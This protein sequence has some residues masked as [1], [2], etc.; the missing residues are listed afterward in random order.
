MDPGAQGSRIDQHLLLARGQFGSVGCHGHAGAIQLAAQRR[1]GGRQA[2][3]CALV[4]YNGRAR[5]LH[6][7]HLVG[8]PGRCEGLSQAQ[9]AAGNGARQGSQ[10]GRGGQLDQQQRSKPA[11]ETGISLFLSVS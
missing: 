6:Q 3:L 4:G 8:V 10:G 2:W 7:I 1:A 5:D 9:R 11:H